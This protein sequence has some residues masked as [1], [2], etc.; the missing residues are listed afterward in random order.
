MVITALVP[1]PIAAPVLGEHQRGRHG[2]G[3]QGSPH[4]GE[5]C[6]PRARGWGP[7]PTPTWSAYGT[8]FGFA[9]PPK[10]PRRSVLNFAAAAH[11]QWPA[12]VVG[13]SGVV[14]LAGGLETLALPGDTSSSGEV[15]TAP[16]VRR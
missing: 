15:V 4:W 12:P 10:A 3:H 11:D 13:T 2:A 6:L 14:A 16:L 9:P 8:G 1:V 5:P 7:P